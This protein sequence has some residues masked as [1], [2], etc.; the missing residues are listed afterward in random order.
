MLYYH[1]IFSSILQNFSTIS[2]SSYGCVIVS[3]PMETY[4]FSMTHT[5]NIVTS[6][7]EEVNVEN[8]AVNE[9]SMTQHGISLPPRDI[10]RD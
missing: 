10:F 2:Q 4:F 1:S 5:R 6:H 7:L 9:R 3:H 8:A